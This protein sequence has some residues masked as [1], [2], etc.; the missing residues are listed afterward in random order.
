MLPILLICICLNGVSQTYHKMLG[1][2]NHWYVSG[3]FL[4]LKS[5]SQSAVGIGGPCIGYYEA[6]KDSTYG[7]KTYKIFTKNGNAL[8]C[9]YSN[10]SPLNKLLIRED[11]ISQK[12]YMV[13][14]D[15]INE[16]VAMD[17][18]MQVGDSLYLPFSTTSNVLKNG[19]YKVDSIRMKTEILGS[20][21]HLFLSKRNA[22]VNSVTHKKFY[23]EWIESIGATHFPVNV[24][25]EESNSDNQLSGNCN[26]KQYSSY[27]TCK[28]TKQV[29]FYQDSCALKF[30]Q[31][32]MY[33]AYNYSGDNCQF[34]G[35]SGGIHELSFINKLELFPN[36]TFGKQLYL[37]FEATEFK[38]VT[39][40]VYNVMG[41]K[42]Y[43]KQYLISTSENVIEL[44]TVE[45]S[46]G[47]YTLKLSSATE[48]SAISFIKN[49]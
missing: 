41:Q 15:S 9:P 14:P 2:S 42:V 22:P 16:S 34:Y 1:D 46:P 35:F 26:D 5:S 31:T 3:F 12:V 28:F 48:S 30:V 24:I 21:K 17:F 33:H 27:V 40:A 11:T 6:T 49:E 8:F 20:R 10:A 45:L 4:G 23:I 38:P 7:S 47:I 44:N 32:G 36:P 18:S 13:H 25:S 19:Y 29:K 37:K 39:I 43:D